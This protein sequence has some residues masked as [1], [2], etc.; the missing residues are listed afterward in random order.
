MKNKNKSTNVDG[1]RKRFPILKDRET[2]LSEIRQNKKL[3]TW[4]SNLKEDEHRERFLDICTG[5]RGLRMTYDGY[6]KYIF[7]TDIHRDRLE[8][9]ISAILGQTVKIKEV[10]PLESICVGSDKTLVIMDIVVELADGSIANVE[11]QKHGYSFPG[12]RAACYAADLLLRQYKRVRDRA[13]V[14]GDRKKSF[15]YKDIKPV[16]TIIFYERSPKAFHEKNQLN[17][18]LHHAEYKANTGVTLNLLQ[19]FYF[20]PLDIFQALYDNKNANTELTAWLMFLSTDDPEAICRLID[21]YPYFEALYKDVY[22]LAANKERVMEMFSKE[23]QELDEG[24]TQYMIDEMADEIRELKG[25]NCD[26]KDENS[27]LK[28][29]NFDLKDE[30]NMLRT[31]KTES[32]NKLKKLEAELAKRGIQIASLL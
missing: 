28:G 30:I 21:A 23:L 27:D 2:V 7:D 18:F 29:E 13:A 22:E 4:F 15:V 26:L 14:S 1:I 17:H 16:Y 19:H 11:M 9:L 6:F 3:Q 8:A 10:L 20:I 31:E 25:E 32:E 24:T 12:E 5:A